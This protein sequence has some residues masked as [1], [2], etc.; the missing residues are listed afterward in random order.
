MNGEVLLE[1]GTRQ[2]KL[3]KR[4]FSYIPSVYTS[5]RYGVYAEHND[6]YTLYIFSMLQALQP[7]QKSL[8]HYYLSSGKLAYHPL[9]A[10][11]YTD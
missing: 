9:Q 1:V 6:E 11:T 5:S 10:T 4:L 7:A 8:F 2:G 3:Q